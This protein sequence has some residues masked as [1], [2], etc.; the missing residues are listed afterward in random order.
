MNTR[1]SNNK[2]TKEYTKLI[3]RKCNYMNFIF[4]QIRAG[5]LELLGGLPMVRRWIL[6]FLNINFLYWYSNKFLKL[7]LVVLLGFNFKSSFQRKTVSYFLNLT[8]LCWFAD[9]SPRSPGTRS[10]QGWCQQD[11][12][13]HSLLFHQIQ[14]SKYLTLNNFQKFWGCNN[15]RSG[16]Q[17]HMSRYNM[18][19]QVRRDW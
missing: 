13:M 17:C 14:N 9:A 7:K 5:F 8:S 6:L 10:C 19:R 3:F 4:F 12:E 1:V 16:S 11:E 18:S 2:N 15:F